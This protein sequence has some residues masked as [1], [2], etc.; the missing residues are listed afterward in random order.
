MAEAGSARIERGL[1]GPLEVAFANDAGLPV[2]RVVFAYPPAAKHTRRHWTLELAIEGLRR[3]SLLA[4]F[5]AGVSPLGPPQLLQF[6]IR[7]TIV[8]SYE[9]TEWLAA[10]LDTIEDEA[11]LVS[12][13]VIDA[14]VAAEALDLRNYEFSSAV[15]NLT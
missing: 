10:R 6:E 13:G 8:L 12:S 3:E 4:L 7:G 14:R 11:A 15:Q 1:D 2:D 5:E 9:P